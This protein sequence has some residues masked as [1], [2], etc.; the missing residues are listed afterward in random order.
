MHHPTTEGQL[1][2][3]LNMAADQSIVVQLDP[4]TRI[5][6]TRPMVIQQHSS[7][8]EPWG[9]DGGYAKLRWQGESGR[10]MLTFQ[11]V[12]G[13]FNRGL[14]IQNLF[15]D[16]NG[17]YGAPAGD[18]LKLYAPDGDPGSLYKFLIRDV[19]TSYATRGIVFEGAI[20]EA[21][22]ENVHAENHNSH[23]MEMLNIENPR[24]IVSNI[25]IVHPNFSRN[26][27]AGLKCLY[28]TNITMGSFVLNAL[29]GVIAPEGIRHASACNGENTGES[30]FVVPWGGYGSVITGCEASSDGSTVARKMVEGQWVDVGRPMLYLLDGTNN[31][32][33]TLNHVSYYG[34]GNNPM[35][36][37]K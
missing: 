4:R 3:L 1:E 16:G 19:Y 26:F 34:Q 36:V 25:N 22:M 32:E 20:F 33:Q 2:E 37:V 8:G 28:S 7:A 21:F 18:C 5:D 9:V 24:G 13:V 35:R 6:L 23:G 14:V 15:L 17:Y 12:N 27:G 30:L 31:V 29:G 11:G 10:D